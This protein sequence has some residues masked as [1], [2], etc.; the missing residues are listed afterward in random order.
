MGTSKAVRMGTHTQGY[1]NGKYYNL[2][3][4]LDSLVEDYK[5]YG[6]ETN[7]TN[8]ILYTNYTFKKKNL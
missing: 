6:L 3:Y 8:R 5:K 7:V 1:H 2:G 4:N